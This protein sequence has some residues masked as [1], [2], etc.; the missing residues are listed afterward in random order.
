MPQHEQWCNP[1]NYQSLCGHFL[2]ESAATLAVGACAT[3][4]AS[5]MLSALNILAAGQKLV[6]LT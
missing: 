1:L 3:G 6:K 4:D 5:C 2:G